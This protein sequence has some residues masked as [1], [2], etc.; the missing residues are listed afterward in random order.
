MIVMHLREIAVATFDGRGGPLK[1]LGT[2]RR[3]RLPIRKYLRR[4]LLGQWVRRRAT[5]GAFAP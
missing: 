4:Q 2:L 3:P 1:G 5:Q